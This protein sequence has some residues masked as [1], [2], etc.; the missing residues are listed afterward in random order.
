MTDTA[1]PKPDTLDDPVWVVFTQRGQP[2]A[3]RERLD[4]LRVFGFTLGQDVFYDRRNR[5][6][7]K[8]YFQAHPEA[9]KPL[10]P[11]WTATIPKDR[12]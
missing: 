8:A 7:V 4:D 11:I 5:A 2:L 9:K 3:W 10:M 1:I 6:D 12:T